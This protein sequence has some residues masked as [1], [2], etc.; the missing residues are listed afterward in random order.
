MNR[1]MKT[2]RSLWKVILLNIRLIGS[3]KIVMTNN[4]KISKKIQRKYETLEQKDLVVVDD[5]NIKIEH[6]KRPFIKIEDSIIRH[7]SI[8]VGLEI[9]NIL[10]K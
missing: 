4:E 7:D 1:Q 2:D 9:M 6:I 5:K 3:P 10:I 8:K